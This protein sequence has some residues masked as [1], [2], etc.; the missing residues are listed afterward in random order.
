LFLLYKGQRPGRAGHQSEGCP[1]HSS[2][3]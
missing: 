2:W 1:F 3:G